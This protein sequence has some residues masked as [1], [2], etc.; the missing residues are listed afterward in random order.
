MSK[1]GKVALWIVGGAGVA[2]VWGAVSSGFASGVLVALT[3]IVA[4]LGAFFSWI[5]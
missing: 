3:I 5:D 2:L 4:L 1:Q